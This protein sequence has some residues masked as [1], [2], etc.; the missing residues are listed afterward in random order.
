M[1]DDRFVICSSYYCYYAI[2]Q[3]DVTTLAKG[4]SSFFYKIQLILV[5]C[6]SL[7]LDRSIR[8]DGHW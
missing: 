6:A 3:L 2:G 7:L 8:P 4:I 5:P 1:D